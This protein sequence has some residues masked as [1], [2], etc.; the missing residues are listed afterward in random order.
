M[1]VII[2]EGFRKRYRHIT[3]ADALLES[4]TGFMPSCFR[5]NTLKTKVESVLERLLAYG[6]TFEP[7]RFLKNAFYVDE[8]KARDTLESFLGYMHFQDSASM[9]PATL[10]PKSRLRGRIL[11]ACAAPGEKTTQIA[12][13]M[14]N[15]G[16]L[17]ANDSSEERIRQL[18]LHL[19]KAGATNAIVTR[20]D[21]RHFPRNEIFDAVILDPPCSGEGMLRADSR[22]L[23]QWSEYLI[24]RLA[25]IQKTM[26]VNAYELVKFG[27][28][29][30]YCTSTFAPE[31]N[32]EVVQHLLR[33]VRGAEL[34]DIRVSGLEKD[35]GLPYWKGRDFDGDMEKCA[36]I[37][38]Q[39]NDTGGLFI[40]K[41]K[42]T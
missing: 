28:T 16:A 34:V 39:Y 1:A 24:R 33:S 40:A 25:V 41:V 17:V 8:P 38:P 31:E 6:I 14:E 36:R 32:E 10:I 37:W 42:R 27:G 19:Q 2:P 3:D 18:R 22:A 5:V 7:V 30:I 21:F 9:I 23:E 12:A 20:Y 26:I 13:L 4:L 29:L 15:R 35:P 11:D